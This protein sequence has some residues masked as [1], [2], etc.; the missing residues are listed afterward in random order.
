MNR[1]TYQRAA[2]RAWRLYKFYEAA[3]VSLESKEQYERTDRLMEKLYRQYWKF[4][5]KS[6]AMCLADD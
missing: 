1:L 4:E 6:T 5:Y 2:K 3:L